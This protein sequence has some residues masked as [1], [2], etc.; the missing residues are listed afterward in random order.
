VNV[1]VNKLF[2]NAE[3]F[4]FRELFIIVNNQSARQSVMGKSIPPE[5]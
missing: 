3:S 4:A 5:N 1:G 2:T